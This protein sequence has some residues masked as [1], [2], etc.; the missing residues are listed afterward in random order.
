MMTGLTEYQQYQLRFFREC[1]IPYDQ[2]KEIYK[3]FDRLMF[4]SDLGG[5]QESLLLAGDTGSGKTVLINNYVSQ[6]PSQKGKWGEMPILKTRIPVRTKEQN[7]LDQFL[8]DLENNASGR[9]KR[10]N[11]QEAFIQGVG[12]ALKQ[13]KVKLIIVTQ[14]QEL[15]KLNHEDERLAIAKILKLISEEA[16]ISF[17]FVGM[18]YSTLIADDSEWNSRLGWH[19]HLEYFHLHKWEKKAQDQTGQWIPDEKGKEHFAKFVAGLSARMGFEYQPNLTSDD[20]LLPLFALCR[21]ECRKLKHFL[22]D[23]LFDALS[24]SEVTVDKKRLERT[25]KMKFP[26][27]ENPFSLKLNELK[28]REQES[29]TGYNKKATYRE[30]RVLARRFTDEL[31]VTALI[32]KSPLK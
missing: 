4:N 5:E 12:K 16:K 1:F 30:D 19:R 22:Y 2:I 10:T 13:K 17:V 28:I 24:N 23:A 8:V 15:V 9:I 27:D 26:D 6:Y 18:P 7:T 25:F 20:I 31:P 14:F 29:E 21:G 11:N 3:V 32:S